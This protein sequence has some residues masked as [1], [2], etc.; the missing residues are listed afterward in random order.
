MKSS[1]EPISA[2][3]I[4]KM[5]ES[6]NSYEHSTILSFKNGSLSIISSIRD[7]STGR[8]LS[9]EQVIS[10][11]TIQENLEHRLKGLL[12]MEKSGEMPTS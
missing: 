1:N 5:I 10:M 12:E 3:F 4:G 11:S 6:P 7:L 2:T 8:L 9:R